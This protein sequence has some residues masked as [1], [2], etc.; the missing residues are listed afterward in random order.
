MLDV[1]MMRQFFCNYFR[2][3]WT[4]TISGSRWEVFSS[5]LTFRWSPLSSDPLILVHAFFSLFYL[6]CMLKCGGKY[7]LVKLND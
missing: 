3:I 2:A 7:L 1:L 6:R 5:F 4:L